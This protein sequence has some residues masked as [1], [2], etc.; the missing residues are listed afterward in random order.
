MQGIFHA[1]YPV[2]LAPAVGALVAIGAALLWR[3][4]RT[5]VAA[6]TPAGAVAV[7]AWWGYHLLARS[8]DFLPWLKWV[9]LAGGLLAAV[10]L[11]TTAIAN[12]AANRRLTFGVRGT[13]GAWNGPC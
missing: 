3:S 12:T 6:G 13:D 10:G 7:S 2:V 11:L 1:Y 8:A 4:R 9:V 5:V